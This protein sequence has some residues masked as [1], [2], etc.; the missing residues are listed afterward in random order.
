MQ[1][2]ENRSTLRKRVKSNDFL[3]GKNSS[4]GILGQKMSVYFFLSGSE[5]CRIKK[6]HFSI[7]L[8]EKD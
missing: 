8:I 3:D 1:I 6:N 2:V 7:K 4:I 5:M